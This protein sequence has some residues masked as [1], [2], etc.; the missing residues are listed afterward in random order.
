MK[1]SIILE[2]GARSP[3]PTEPASSTKIVTVRKKYGEKF[4]R[5]DIAQKVANILKEAGN[6]ASRLVVSDK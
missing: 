6:A 1:L 4:Y 5:F 3:F 2:L